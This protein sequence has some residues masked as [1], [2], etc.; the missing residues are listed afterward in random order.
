MPGPVNRPGKRAPDKSTIETSTGKNLN[1]F[2]SFVFMALV[3][4]AK[5]GLLLWRRGVFQHYSFL[6][7]LLH[8]LFRVLLEIL[9]TG[10]A[11]K[12]N[13]LAFVID[14]DFL[15]GFISQNG[16]LQLLRRGPLGQW[17]T[18]QNKH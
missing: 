14:K 4:L 5:R 13:P 16:T 15:A 10:R 8:V 18:G 12:I 7:K 3:F 9:D 11:A 2:L 6:L 17:K 1:R